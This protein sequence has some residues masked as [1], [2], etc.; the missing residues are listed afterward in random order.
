MVFVSFTFQKKYYKLQKDIQDL[1]KKSLIEIEKD[2]YSSR[3]NCN[4]KILK[5]T[6]PKKYR[7]RVKNYRIIYSGIR[8]KH[9]KRL[10]RV[11]LKPMEI[12]HHHAKPLSFHR[13]YL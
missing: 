8:W 10:R 4:I 6:T 12:H 13:L 1:I 2:P 3:P 5:N 7:L 11:Q 9:P